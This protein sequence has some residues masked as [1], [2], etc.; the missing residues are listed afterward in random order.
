M[1]ENVT[2]S[3]KLMGM[4]MTAIFLVII[5]IYITVLILHRLTN[6]KPGK[7]TT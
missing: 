6:K 5:V 4:G 7:K 3:L 1:I 2:A